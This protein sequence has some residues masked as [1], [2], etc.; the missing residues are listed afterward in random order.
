MQTLYEH[1]W[2]RKPRDSA[3][4]LVNMGRIFNKYFKLESRKLYNWRRGLSSF[5]RRY[6][7][8]I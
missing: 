7:Y 2:S 3:R 1:R 8:L 4:K 6:F 5:L